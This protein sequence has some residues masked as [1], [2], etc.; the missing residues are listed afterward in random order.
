MG[1]IPQICLSNFECEI[2][3]FGNP[4]CILPW[5][6]QP[7]RPCARQLHVILEFLPLSMLGK[8]SDIHA[9]AIWLHPWAAMAGRHHHGLDGGR[10]TVEPLL[11]HSTRLSE[12]GARGSLDRRYA[13]CLIVDTYRQHDFLEE[14]KSHSRYS[15]ITCILRVYF[16]LLSE[17]CHFRCAENP[18]DPPS[19]LDLV[20]LRDRRHVCEP[21]LKA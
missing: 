5:L 12:P 17:P 4:P 20:L 2:E 15:I 10:W 21:Q 3:L 6:G 7:Q 11:S 1:D 18:P 19:S 16:P 9:T 14:T 13:C 8:T